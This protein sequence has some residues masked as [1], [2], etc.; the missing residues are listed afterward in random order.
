MIH[1]PSVRLL[2]STPDHNGVN[3]GWRKVKTEDT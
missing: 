2:K 1:V 3:S